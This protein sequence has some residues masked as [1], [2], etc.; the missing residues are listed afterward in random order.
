MRIPKIS[1]QAALRRP[2]AQVL[3]RT[4][5]VSLL[6]ALLLPAETMPAP[7]YRGESLARPEGYRTWMF[8][9]ASY[10]MGYTEGGEKKE[11]P[12]TFHNIYIQREAFEAYRRSGKFPDKT[13]LVMEVIRPGTNASINKRGMFQDQFAGVEVALKDESRFPDKWAYFNF[14]GPGGQALAEAK[15][16]ARERCWSCH[17]E[18]GAVDNVFVQFYPVLREARPGR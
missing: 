4:A 11:S 9:G 5:A 14:I 15:P 10:G 1:R 3:I 16:F 7:K 17:N 6:S 13:M 8:V 2:A 12:A 18:H